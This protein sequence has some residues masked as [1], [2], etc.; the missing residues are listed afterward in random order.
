MKIFQADEGFLTILAHCILHCILF[1]LHVLVRVQHRW[2]Y[3]ADGGQRQFLRFL[4][5][6]KHHRP[7]RLH[8]ERSTNV[9]IGHHCDNGIVLRRDCG[10]D[11]L[12]FVLGGTEQA[13]GKKNNRERL[14]KCERGRESV[15]RL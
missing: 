6:W 1:H 4:L 13:Q 12:W 8:L 9:P 11:N 3:Q 15:G 5:C 7:I 14:A 10:A 2:Q